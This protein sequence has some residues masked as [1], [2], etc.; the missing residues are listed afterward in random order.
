VAFA[1]LPVCHV[2]AGVTV[3]GVRRTAVDVKTQTATVVSD[4]ATTSVP[5]LRAALDRAGYPPHA[6]TLADG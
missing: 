4:P 6:E 1:A 5:A 3:P 2:P